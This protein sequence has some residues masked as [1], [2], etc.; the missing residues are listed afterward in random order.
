M[1]ETTTQ[2]IGLVLEGGAMRGMFSAGVLDVLIEQGIQLDTVVGVSAGAAFGCNYK[3]QQ[4][5]RVLRYNSLMAH[6]WRYCSVWSWILTGD[7]FGAE[8]AYHHVPTKIDI[9]DADT[10]RN[11]PSKFYLVCTDVDTGKA[12][13]HRID[14]FNHN[15]LEWIRA[16]A[17]MPICA[18][19][20]HLD[21]YK[22]LDG[23]VAD[24]IPLEFT[25]SLGLKR[26]IV[27]LTQPAGYQK[28]P[29][30]VLPLM[31]FWLRK[32]PNMVNAIA[33][34]HIMYNAQLE[35]VRQEECQGNAFVIRPPFALPIG[36]IC[37]DPRTMKRVYEIGR[38]IATENLPQIL[39]FINTTQ[40]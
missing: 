28:Q 5:G 24:S 1:N 35:F 11:H 20:V 36:H 8:F 18:K 10:F 38:S 27:V 22:L 13:Y 19:I 6:N 40:I 9:F 17:S 12:V 29:N 2:P 16:S 34:R 39:E 30:S 31:K 3:S 15:A 37:H 21:G 14:E 23:G 25:Q 7:L 4:A 26:N 33:N 32:H